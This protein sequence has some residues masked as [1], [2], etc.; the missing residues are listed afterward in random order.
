MSLA[1]EAAASRRV[2]GG[3]DI[4]VAVQGLSKGTA[5]IRTFRARRSSARACPQAWLLLGLIGLGL[6]A[7]SV[8]VSSQLARSLLLPLAAVALASEL[9]ADGDLS[10]RAPVDGPPEV[11]QVSRGLNRLAARIGELLAHERE[12]LADM[13]HRLRT[14]L[15]ALRIDAESLRDHAEMMQVTSDVDALTRTVTRSSARRAGRRGEEAGWHATLP[16]S[17][18]SARRSGRR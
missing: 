16:R 6:L 4:L 7:L 12:T 3:E 8:I 5:V 18:G 9:L 11:R 17:S 2:T 15:T 13:S 14:P 10:A 1:G